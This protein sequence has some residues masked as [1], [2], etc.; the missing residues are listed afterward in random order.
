MSIPSRLLLSGLFAI[1][2]AVAQD[3]RLVR[4]AAA[5]NAGSY[6]PAGLPHSGIAPGA[7]AALQRY[8]QEAPNA[9]DRAFVQRELDKLGGAQ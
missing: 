2:L 1:S 7:R 5:L 8:L 9:D 3:P 6:T 4:N